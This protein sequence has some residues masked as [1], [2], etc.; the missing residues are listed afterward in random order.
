MTK[1]H[2]S[3]PILELAGSPA[4]LGAAHGEAQR[5]RIRG[6]AER[7]LDYILSTAAVRVSEAELWDRWTPQVAVNQRLAPDLVEEMRGIAR[8]AGVSF[9]RIFMLN[10]MLDLNS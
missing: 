6:H 1:P 9:E 5:D 10:S 4:Q 2:P 3:I 7:F 8:G